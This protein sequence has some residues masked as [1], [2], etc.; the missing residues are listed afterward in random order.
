MTGDYFYMRALY[1]VWGSGL[2]TYGD[3]K[4]SVTQDP[5]AAFQR[6]RRAFER[7]WCEKYGEHL[8]RRGQTFAYWRL[9]RKML[10]H[11]AVEVARTGP[12]E[13]VCM[14]M[15][16]HGWEKVDLMLPP[17]ELI[18][19]EQYDFVFPKRRRST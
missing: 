14:I 2:W 19:V 1:H 7:M 6:D 8:G 10:W 17:G 3:Q 12:P 18:R 15:S 13:R 4:G 5:F 16:D 11:E 9:D